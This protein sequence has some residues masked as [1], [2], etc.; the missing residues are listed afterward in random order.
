MAYAPPGEDF[1][2]GVTIGDPP[3][4]IGISRAL[5]RVPGANLHLVSRIL[6]PEPRWSASVAE[7]SRGRAGWYPDRMGRIGLAERSRREGRVC[8][9]LKT[10]LTTLRLWL[11]LWDTRTGQLLW[12]SS[13]E[14]TVAAQLLTQ[15][16]AAV[17][18]E[19]IAQRLWSRIIQDDLLGGATRSRVFFHR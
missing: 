10:R 13:G 7:M 9:L 16:S 12:E 17:S 4:G 8:K 18:L 15:E 6:Q 5:A 3:G 2:E 11:Q 14:G 1:K 19:D